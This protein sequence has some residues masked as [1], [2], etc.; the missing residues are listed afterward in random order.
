MDQHWWGPVMQ[1]TIAGVLMALV[2]TWVAKSRLQ[3]RPAGD[4]RRMVH[5]PSTLIIGFA[6]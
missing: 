5:P 6:H 4:S 3:T 2:M 1:T